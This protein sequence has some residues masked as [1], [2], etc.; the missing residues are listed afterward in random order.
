MCSNFSS[1]ILTGIPPEGIRQ[2]RKWAMRGM[3]R[4]L[5]TGLCMAA[6]AMAAGGQKK[7]QTVTSQISAQ[8]F[9]YEVVSIRPN[10]SGATTSMIAAP[11]NAFR[12]TNMPLSWLVQS[13]Y[14]VWQENE[15]IGLPKWAESDRYDVEAKIDEETVTALKKLP[16]DERKQQTR[17]MTLA[18]LEERCHF[19]AHVEK[20]VVPAYDLVVDAG[21]VKMKETAAEAK[22]S[23]W[24]GRGETRATGIQTSDLA[25]SL[26]GAV[27]RRIIDKTG[28][29][30]K[31]FDVEIKWTP[32]EQQGTPEA[33][34]SIYAVLREQLGL[35]LVPSK[36]VVGVVVV[37]RMERPSE[38]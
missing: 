36:T 14:M 22:P 12:M 38:N 31:R 17:Q 24:F 32:D 13:A 27:G 9:R 15:V 21:G 23:G 3:R 8:E 25:S 10:K 37:E 4:N 34:P 28:L 19:K 30:E 18:I 11:E 7:A 1:L 35:K 20:R 2:R 33:E 6:V 16:K 26:S 29:G 5:L